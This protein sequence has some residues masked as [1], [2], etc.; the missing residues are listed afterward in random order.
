MEKSQK[1]NQLKTLGGGLNYKERDP[2][3]FKF[4]AVYS[5]PKIEE[6]PDEYILPIL[7]I[8]DQATTFMC[9]AF[10]STLVSELQENVTLTPLYTYAKTKQIMG[11]PGAG[12]AD[13]ESAC[14]SHVEYGALAEEDVD[15]AVLGDMGEKGE[16]YV[17]DWRNWSASFDELAKKH[18][19]ASYWEI[20]PKQ[21]DLFDSI[22]ATLWANRALEQGAITGTYWR[23]GWDD[24]AM[25]PKQKAEGGGGH[26]IAIVGWKKIDGEDFLVIPNSYGTDFGENGYN[27]FPR[28]VVNREFKFGTFAFTDM[29][30]AQAE[31][32]IEKKM[33]IDDNESVKLL[34]L[35]RYFLLALFK[36]IYGR[37]NS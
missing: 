27:Y 30:R 28:E 21:Y 18:K 16:A 26:L 32:L 23:N 8:K 5:L 14:K 15:P 24:R 9:T 11:V 19:K 35:F 1:I 13:I 10:G 3:N 4:G 17:S 33:K 6:L 7:G 25:I 34:K 20:E 36:K 31:K 12:G 29:P 37:S 2:R 22:R